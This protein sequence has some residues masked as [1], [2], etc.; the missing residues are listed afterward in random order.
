MA[1]H[2]F[3]PPPARL[4]T[5]AADPAYNPAVPQTRQ[6]PIDN[7][8]DGK[9]LSVTYHPGLGEPKTVEAYGAT[10][11]AGEAKGIDPKFRQ[12]VAGNPYFSIDGQKTA[13]DDQRE[14]AK[15]DPDLEDEDDN[16]TFDE[17]VVA[18]RM[19]EYGTSDPVAA[20]QM[21]REGET[22]FSRVGTLRRRG[23]PPKE[24]ARAEAKARAEEQA[25][26]L[27]DIESERND[28]ANAEAERQARIN[29]ARAEEARKK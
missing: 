17:N 29:A 8:P 23:R 28:E 9:P 20:E 4:N 14:K 22:N 21:R 18:N 5:P 10:F 16:L 19:E 2:N 1:D 12:K 15:E 11:K 26:D 3:I 25:A 6:T 7:A 27:S 13:G 24:Q